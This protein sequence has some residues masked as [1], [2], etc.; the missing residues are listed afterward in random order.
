MRGARKTKHAQAHLN[1]PTLVP[2]GPGQSSILS[3]EPRYA[4]STLGPAPWSCSDRKRA[5]EL[6]G[7]AAWTYS[8]SDRYTGYTYY[9]C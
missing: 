4:R 1:L 5:C 9:Y 7:P 2:S 3:G 8:P 6:R